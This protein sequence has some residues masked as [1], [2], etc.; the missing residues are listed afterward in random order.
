MFYDFNTTAYGK[1]I[2]AGEHSVLRGHPALV[3]PAHDKKLSLQ[4]Q[5]STTALTAVCTDEQNTDITTLFWKVVE[6]GLQRLNQAAFK[7]VGQIQ[8]QNNIPIGVGMGASAAL[9][10]V[11]SRWFAAQHL[12]E[13]SKIQFFAQELE[14]LFHGQSSGLDIAGSCASTGILFQKRN[15]KPVKQAWQPNWSLSYCGEPGITSSCIKQ[16]QLLWQSNPTQA[17]GIDQQ[18]HASVLAAKVALEKSEPGSLQQL[19]D[20]INNAADCFLQW[21]LISESLQEH[22][23]LLRSQGALAVKPTGS[24]GGGYVLSLWD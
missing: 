23:Q 6:Y 7:L 1:W 19:T 16:V 8:L 9:C 11:I 15:I 2:L 24:G 3:F 10:V 12:I 17:Q 20:A 22:M 13:S 5:A 4:Y 21:G 18:M 14:H